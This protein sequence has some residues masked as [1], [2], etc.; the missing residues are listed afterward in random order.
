MEFTDSLAEPTFADVTYLSDDRTE[1]LDVYLPA[2]MGS[3][4][5]PAIVHF[6]GGGWKSGDKAYERERR[7]SRRLSESGYVT[8]SA[9]YRLT[10]YADDKPDG[11]PIQS[12]WP[13]NL[14]DCKSAIRFVRAN[15]G[16]FGVDPNRIGL[17]GASAGA[18]LALLT[19]FTAGVPELD[20]LGSWADQPSHVACVVSAYGPHRLDTDNLGSRFHFGQPLADVE[21]ILLNASPRRYFHR[22]GPPVY[23]FHPEDDDLVPITMAHEML[24]DFRR[25]GI[26]HEFD[27]PDTG[28][29]GLHFTQ[30]AYWPPILRFLDRHLM[31]SKESGRGSLPLS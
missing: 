18:H 25:E 16:R 19:A 31:D 3:E 2:E 15:A 10:T 14:A 26:E 17:T 4:L 1:K 11:P 12:C 23:V 28:G 22:G 27:F 8:F 30:D 5:R 21:E 24:D 20:S 13:D 9:N 29:H 6:H 7:I